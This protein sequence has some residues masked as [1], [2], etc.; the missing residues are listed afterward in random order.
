MSNQTT[1]FQNL[2]NVRVA[3]VNQVNT[4]SEEASDTRYLVPSTT[5]TGEQ[6]FDMY[7]VI[8]GAAT[9]VGRTTVD[10]SN[11]LTEA[12]QATDAEVDAVVNPVFT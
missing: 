2:K 12:D 9:K 3:S 8:D 11:Y 6:G 7:M 4:A 1:P 5:E 10:L